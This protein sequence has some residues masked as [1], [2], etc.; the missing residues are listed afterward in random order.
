MLQACAVIEAI[1]SLTASN[2]YYR[3][4]QRSTVLSATNAA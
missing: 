1:G 2:A 4:Q 3:N